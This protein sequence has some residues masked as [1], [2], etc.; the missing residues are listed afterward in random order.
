MNQESAPCT[1]PNAEA[2]WKMHAQRHRAGEEARRGH[3]VREDDRELRVERGEPVELLPLAHEPH[4]LPITAP[5]RSRK[6][7]E[8]LALAAVER[9]AFAV[10]AQPHQRKAEVGLEALLVEVEADQRR[11]MRCV[12]TG[13]D[14]G[15]DERRPT[16]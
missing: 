14:D 12:S 10:L 8:L 15:V 2:V 5:K 1:W 3:D 9:H 4:Q 16:P 11:P 13:A 6:P 7:A